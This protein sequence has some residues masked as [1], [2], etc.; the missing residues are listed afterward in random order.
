MLMCPCLCW[1]EDRDRLSCPHVLIGAQRPF[2]RTAGGKPGLSTNTARVVMLHHQHVLMSTTWHDKSHGI[3][4]I[5]TLPS[6]FFVSFGL[7]REFEHLSLWWKRV[8]ECFEKLRPRETT[9]S[10]CTTTRETH[11]DLSSTTVNTLMVRSQPASCH[12]ESEP[13]S[14][15]N[16]SPIL[17]LVLASV[18][19]RAYLSDA[20]LALYLVSRPSEGFR[21][22]S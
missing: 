6:Y 20:Q 2:P 18:T 1:R 5:S 8:L 15:Q 22:G 3:L 7:D 19:L 16:Y 4:L 21:V 9:F 10:F 11:R 17:V 13:Q 14:I 12:R